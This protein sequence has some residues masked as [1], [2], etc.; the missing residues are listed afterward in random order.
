MVVQLPLEAL[1]AAV[2][3]L[4]FSFL[5]LICSA[6]VI[7]LVWKHHEK[8]SYIA[9]LGYFTFIC[10]AASIAQQL[11]T[12]VLWRDIKT[13]QFHY[14]GQNFGSPVIALA[15]P[16][17]GVDLILFY[18]QF[19]C[20]N[21]E[22][23]LVLTW[24]LAL[25][26]SI[27]Y[28]SLP[29]RWQHMNGGY[30]SLTAKITAVLLP[31]LLISL[32]QLEVIQQSTVGFLV[33]SDITL[34]AS[35][36][37]ATLIIIAILT[38]HINTRRRLHRWHFRH[39]SVTRAIDSERG[40]EAANREHNEVQNTAYDIWLIGRF[41]IAV[42]FLEGFLILEIV[43][44]F[45]QLAHNRPEKYPSTPDLSAGRANAD[46][47]MFVPGV[48]PS[49][50]YFIVFGTSQSFRR[51]LY[52]IL[53][54]RRFRRVPIVR[55]EPTSPVSLSLHQTPYHSSRTTP[56]T[57]S[58]YAEPRVCS[59]R[60]MRDESRPSLELHQEAMISKLVKYPELTFMEKTVRN[61]NDSSRTTSKIRYS[62]AGTSGSSERASYVGS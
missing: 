58:V 25:A 50:L 8:G 45:G 7:L 4:I 15:G 22:S 21:V 35:I 36:V 60:F 40:P 23:L 18:I 48:A 43:S 38:K 46:F 51:T 47:P 24:A 39:F 6:L 30:I 53:V 56:R 59:F 3:V 29:V 31:L 54:P 52:M 19:Y 11:H 27:F 2:G 10:A 9:L 55:T 37:G 57:Q 14:A 26:Y 44:E 5:C 28:D 42:L 1:G 34:V 17:T 32:L 16:S 49:L 33:L 61:A 13:D 12:I 20:H 41:A 62:E